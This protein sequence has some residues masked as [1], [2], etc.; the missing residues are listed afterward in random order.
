MKYKVA[1]LI[2]IVLF[3][4]TTEP[5]IMSNEKVNWKSKIFKWDNID[6]SSPER[7]LLPGKL[8]NLSDSNYEAIKKYMK[9]DIDKM[10]EFEKINAIYKYMKDKNNFSSYAA[11][12]KLISK[13]TVDEIIFD[14]TLSGCH[15]WGIVLTSILRKADIP[16]VFV[17]TALIGWAE[18]YL[19]NESKQHEG[20]IFI[21][22]YI[23]EDWILLDSTKQSIIKEYDP[24]NPVI[25]FSRN[26]SNYFVMFKGLDPRDYGIFG[27]EDMMNS[28]DWGAKDIIEGSK[29][30]KVL[31]QITSIE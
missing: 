10:E 6:Y 19:K 8:T 30:Y 12:G 25:G 21:E 14:K 31:G 1:I 4:C 28:M 18:S 20:H 2:I 11:G 9:K 5:T 16:A 26:G 22:A 3:G 15:D 24:K 7:Y 23:N 17:D 29:E 27:P 13:R